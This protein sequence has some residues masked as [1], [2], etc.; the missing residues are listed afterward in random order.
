MIGDKALIRMRLAHKRPKAVWVW[1]GITDLPWASSWHLYSDLWAHPEIVIEPKDNIKSLDLRFLTGLQV[2]IDG[3]D[4]T[5]RMFA[6][7]VACM[8]AGAKQVFTLH[9]GE[10]I[11]D[12]G[13]EIGVS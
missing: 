11:Y 5:D 4:T 7:H 6:A 8:K 12:Q 2:H 10:L 1:V 3:N 13:E 9:D